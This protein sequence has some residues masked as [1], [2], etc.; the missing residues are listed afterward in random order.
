[1]LVSG[2]QTLENGEAV[3]VKEAVPLELMFT[4]VNV[5]SYRVNGNGKVMGAEQSSQLMLALVVPGT[6]VPLP[7]VIV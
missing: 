6:R 7:L 4:A 3:L 1:M 2:K 5:W